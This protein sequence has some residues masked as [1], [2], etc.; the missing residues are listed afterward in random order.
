MKRIC[1]G[2]LL[3]FSIYVTLLF[4]TQ[5]RKPT[6][7][8]HIGLRTTKYKKTPTIEIIIPK[9]KTKQTNKKNHRNLREDIEDERQTG[10]VNANPLSSKS[11]PE[12]FRHRVHARTQV[13][14]QEEPSEH[15][16]G[17]DGLED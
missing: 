6:S 7:E 1:F 3:L 11:Q 17:V 12:I 5:I 14:R 8:N 4:T 16:E 13:H 2:T 15:Y 9:T 10:E